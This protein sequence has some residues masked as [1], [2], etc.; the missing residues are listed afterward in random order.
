MLL[1]Y[2]LCPFH[3]EMLAQTLDEKLGKF[4]HNQAIY[5]LK[6]IL[7]ILRESEGGEMGQR[8]RERENAMQALHCQHGA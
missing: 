5:L 7:F 4:C 3:G 6:F 2:S 8:E 1:S